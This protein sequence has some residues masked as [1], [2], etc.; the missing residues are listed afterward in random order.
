MTIL[1]DYTFQMCYQLST[2]FWGYS[3]CRKIQIHAIGG[4]TVKCGLNV[5]GHL[6][7]FDPKLESGHL[8]GA[9]NFRA[10]YT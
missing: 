2:L 1:K 6:R 10:K 4:G 3:S 5:L 7:D 8:L 9:G